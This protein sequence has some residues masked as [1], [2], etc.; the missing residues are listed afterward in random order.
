MAQS[1]PGLLW[2]FTQLRCCFG[3]QPAPAV[4]SLLLGISSGVFLLCRGCGGSW[5]L[6]LSTSGVFFLLNL[7]EGIDVL[8]GLM[9][10]MSASPLN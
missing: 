6:L 10:E 8:K 3:P 7:P 9:E 1:I 5:Y 4:P 2:C